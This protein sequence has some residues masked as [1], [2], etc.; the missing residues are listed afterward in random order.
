MNQQPSQVAVWVAVQTAPAAQPTERDRPARRGFNL[1][2]DPL[3]GLVAWVVQR[4]VTP[5]RGQR[6]A[7]KLGL[8][9]GRQKP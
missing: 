8:P 7:A 4:V 3:E 5:E 1:L 6:Y 2:L 9:G